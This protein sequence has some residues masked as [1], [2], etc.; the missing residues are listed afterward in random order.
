MTDAAR[1]T[2]TLVSACPRLDVVDHRPGSGA[3]FGKVLCP[4]ALTVPVRRWARPY[5]S[6]GEGARSC[7]CARTARVYFVYIRKESSGG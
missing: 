4:D 1:R 5:F 3:V 7:I 2:P 6:L